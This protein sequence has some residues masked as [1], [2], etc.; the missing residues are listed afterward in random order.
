MSTRR[1]FLA[2]LA[3]AACAGC[4]S[5]P[6]SPAGESS[7]GPSVVV[8]LTSASFNG[9]VLAHGATWMVEFY[10]PGCPY[11]R[12]MTT[13][14]ERLALDFRDR[15]SVGKVNV[16]VEVALAQTYHVEAIPTFIFFRNG[17]EL[18]RYVGATSYETLAE[19]L[20]AAEAAS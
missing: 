8:T 16:D 15:A 5:E 13:T 18:S 3:L 6:T 20:R 11:C 17:R 1:A 9:Q 7:D 14:V 4:G 19:M 2:V 10:S 12:A